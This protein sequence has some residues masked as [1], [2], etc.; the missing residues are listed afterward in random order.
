MP[1]TAKQRPLAAAAACTHVLPLLDQLPL[2]VERQVRLVQAGITDGLLGRHQQLKLV[3]GRKLH[4]LVLGQ[5]LQADR[6][7]GAEAAA[8]AGAQARASAVDS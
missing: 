7:A 8:Q 4:H 5:E 6:H 1:A 2:L 3:H